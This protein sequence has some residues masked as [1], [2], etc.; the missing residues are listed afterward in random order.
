MQLL[1]QNLAIEPDIQIF[2]RLAMSAVVRLGGNA[3]AA[4]LSLV[5]ASRR[6][7]Q[8]GAGTGYPL[9]V[10]LQLGT[11]GLYLQ[12][13]GL[14][15]LLVVELP[16]LPEEHQVEEVRRELKQATEI[17]DPSLL[18][19]RNAEMT[20]YIDETRAR[21]ERELELLQEALASRQQALLESL[22]KAET[23][24][25]T[26]LYNR[27]AFD[28]RFGTAFRRTQRQKNEYISLVLLDLD[29]FKQVNDMHGHQ[30]GDAYLN[31][32]AE[33][34]LSVIRRDVDLAFRLGGDEFALLIM[35]EGE[36]ACERARQILHAMDGRVSI[37]IASMQGGDLD[38]TLEAFFELADKA[39]YQ[40]KRYGRGRVVMMNCAFGKDKGCQMQIC[41]K[42]S[43]SA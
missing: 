35:A 15:T 26:G 32:M 24:P 36:I 5:E 43:S 17:T 40:A 30:Y 16:H 3:Y 11:N 14:P 18:L 21:T 37:G 6:L 33:A 38:M 7:R 8:A 4:S 31:R 2:L 25:L 22:R 12:A 20:R 1:E 41:P 28:E 27:R 42:K 23:D 29:H 19:R 13:E 39:L 10:S 34:M 9:P